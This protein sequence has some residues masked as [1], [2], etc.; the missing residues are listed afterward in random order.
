MSTAADV[1][2]HLDDDYLREFAEPAGYLDFARVGP[3][4]DVVAR[5]L[6]D[7]ALALRTDPAGALARLQARTEATAAS[8]A[9]LLRAAPH[10]VAFVTSTSHGLFAAAAALGGD[11][12][13]LVPRGEFPSNVHP[14]L[15][16]Q[17]RGGPR[18][19]WI[20]EPRLT[21][22]LLAGLLDRDVRALTISA[23]DALTGYR[24]PL[25]AFKEVLG[26]D[27]LLIVDAMQGLGAVPLDV[28]AADVLAC[29]GQKWLRS[30]WGAALLLVRDRI[31]DR[32]GPG[33]GGWSG[34][35][36]PFAAA[37][38]RPYTADGN[39]TA[40]TTRRPPQEDEPLPGAVAHTMT[41]PDFLAVAAL[42]AGIDLLLS[43]GVESV[44]RTV[45]RTLGLLLDTVRAAGGDVLL[46]GLT[47]DE[48][49][50]IGSF[51]LPGTDPAQVHAALAAAGLTTTVRDGWVR[52]SPHAT[53]PHTTAE[54][55][56]SALRGVRDR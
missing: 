2:V 19:R 46:D 30:G 53:T 25:G 28:E 42:G 26:P 24:A 45:T 33:L 55:L 50:G 39:T 14:W 8:A 21:P 27:R 47:P 17:D 1:N 37:R 18:V 29:G 11:G 52:L 6:A 49:G 44:G 43:A 56:A 34:R 7:G 13:V 48:R 31:A 10:E 40:D 54:P 15:R 36:D 4:S 5:T 9:T 3:V 12:V 51:R 41:N 32:L 23:V 38:R 22:E 35:R 20:D 16:F